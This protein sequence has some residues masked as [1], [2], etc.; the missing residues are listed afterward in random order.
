MTVAKSGLQLTSLVKSS[1]EL[2][3][4][5]ARAPV[6]EPGDDEILVRVDATPINP[7]D[8]AL[9][10]GGADLDRASASEIDG[11][12]VITAPVA[13]AFMRGS[14]ARIDKPLPVGNEGAGVVVAAGV[15]VAAQ[16]L[17]GKTVSLAGGAMY[18]QYRLAKAAEAF[19][20]PDDASAA[21]GASSFVNPMTALGFVETMRREGHHALVNTAA[22]SNL[23]QMLVKL[24]QADGIPLVNIVRSEA[25]AKLL[26]D[27]GAAHVCDSSSET[28]N[29]DLVAALLETGALLAF[30][31]V[32]GGK[33]AGQILTAMDTALNRRD[34]AY[35]P[36]GST[37]HK[38]I[39]LYGVLD[40]SPTVLGHSFGLHWGAGGWLVSSFL[41]KIGPEA[42]AKMRARVAADLKTIF[43]S[44]YTQEISLV[45]ALDLDTLLA[46]RRTATGEKYL[47]N[48]HKGLA[49]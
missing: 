12:P 36:Y 23:G 3:L 21:D 34:G 41:K 22:A 20:L 9:L 19:V 47:I 6:P 27:L 32:G 8:L 15:S 48:P 26:R 35:S 37:T 46:Y 29:D 10:V 42:A 1:G 24:C 33:L 11:L 5:L 18:A 44:H 4:S 38:Q 7:S 40:M 43:A 17:V 31:A 39:Y 28:F 25:Q 45:E 14:T 49:A 30:D 13:P 16:A 2:E